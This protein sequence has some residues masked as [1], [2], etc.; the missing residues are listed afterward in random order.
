MGEGSLDGRVVLV[1]RP[2]EQ[3][4]ELSRMLLE[5]GA[6]VY[7]AP[8]IELVAAPRRMLEQAAKQLAAGT[9]EWV[10]F[11]S[12]AGV[13]AIASAMART[14]GRFDQTP[15]RVAAVGEGTARALESF[16]A[17]PDLVPSTFTT[18]ALAQAMP[19]G[20]GRVLLARADIAPGA[21]EETLVRKG[22]TPVRVDAYRTR[23][24]S[25]LPD[26]AAK[27]LRDGAV[28]AV[29]FTSASTVE[30]FVAMAGH[31]G[32][33]GVRLPGAVCIGP[34]TAAAA[35]RAGFRV[36][37]VARP[38]TINGLVAALERALRPRRRKES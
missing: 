2:P 34:V 17:Q 30:G 7:S 35:R 32:E 29:T 33:A 6:R 11:T 31:L 23:H 20:S 13:E 19:R 5:R 28:D 8:A 22:W 38:H 26:D 3:S 25:R 4:V 37:A 15:S 36:V 14:G 16:G 1:T 10:V 12:R 24:A 9:F 27:A 21:L 18:S